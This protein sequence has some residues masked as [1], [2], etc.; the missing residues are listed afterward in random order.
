MLKTTFNV[1][2][3][4]I[5]GVFHTLVGILDFVWSNKLALGGA[6]LILVIY[7]GRTQPKVVGSGR[8][9]KAN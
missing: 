5:E 9:V 6:L 2:E 3:D 1:S 7:L 8:K 4:V